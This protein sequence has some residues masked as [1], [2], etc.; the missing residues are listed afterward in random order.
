MLFVC[1]NRSKDSSGMMGT[2][3]SWSDS[4]AADN[5][6]SGSSEEKFVASSW[7][8]KAAAFLNKQILLLKS[9]H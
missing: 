2:S 5:D 4:S 8:A 9:N 7:A 3:Q 6:D 1:L